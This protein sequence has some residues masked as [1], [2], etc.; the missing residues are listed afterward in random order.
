MTTMGP[1]GPA[2]PA[3]ATGA[4]G[5]T[6]YTGQQGKTDLAGVSGPTGATGATGPQGAVGMT[7]AQGPLAS[8]GASSTGWS[9]YRSYDF[10]VARDDIR[11][12]DSNKAAQVADH[13]RN[14]PTYRV[15]LDGT[16]NRRVGAVRDA[17]IAAG[18]PASK[19]QTGAYGDPQLRTERHVAVLVSN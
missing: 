11:D 3:G 10:A 14:N 9:L 4:Q 8:A 18:V 7:G 12:V 6:G 19:I 1:T 2:G 5:S 16:S 13:M 17:L 15:A